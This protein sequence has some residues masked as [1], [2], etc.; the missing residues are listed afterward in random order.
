MNT[1]RAYMLEYQ[2]FSPK[3]YPRS[4]LIFH[5]LNTLRKTVGEGGYPI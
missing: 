5:L 3:R 1:L 2:D 4:G